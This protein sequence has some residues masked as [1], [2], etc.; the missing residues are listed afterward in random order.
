[1]AI[2]IPSLIF[3]FLFHVYWCSHRNFLILLI[4]TRYISKSL[5]K[6]SLEPFSNKFLLLR[7]VHN[8]LPQS[9]LQKKEFL[10]VRF[11]DCENEIIKDVT[12]KVASIVFEFIEIFL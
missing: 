4:V 10:F 12:K 3:H 6:L 9:Y 2:Q 11:I 1:M 5:P 8:F 7:Q